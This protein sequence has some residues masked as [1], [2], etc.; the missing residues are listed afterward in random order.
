MEPSLDKQAGWSGWRSGVG[1]TGEFVSGGQARQM[2]TCWFSFSRHGNCLHTVYTIALDM[3]TDTDLPG[4]HQ[5]KEFHLGMSEPGMNFDHEEEHTRAAGKLYQYSWAG[6]VRTPL[7]MITGWKGATHWPSSLK[8]LENNRRM[9]YV[10]MRELSYVCKVNPLSRNEKGL[11][12][13][14]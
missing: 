1:D 3:H 6:A 8:A 2:L 7:R 11:N 4:R 14:K 13:R 9:S 12:I 10:C 5:N